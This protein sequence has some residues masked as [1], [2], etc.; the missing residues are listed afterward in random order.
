MRVRIP[1]VALGLA[2]AL[3]LT[4]CSG[5]SGGTD[6]D[7][8]ATGAAGAALTIAK[9]DGAIAP[10]SNNPWVGD[11]SG[12]KLGYI[13][14]ILEPLGF[15]N[16][17]DPSDEV[18]PWLAQEITWNEDYTAVT[19]VARDGVTWSDGEDFTADDIAFTFTLLRD[20]PELDNAALGIQDVAVAGATVTISFA[21]SM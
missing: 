7:G 6:D 5:G 16:L 17:I 13:N 8:T 18:T 21:S 1:A 4:A 9:P 19:L 10:E 15:V 14:A 12:M 2:A 11:A 3:A 20:Q